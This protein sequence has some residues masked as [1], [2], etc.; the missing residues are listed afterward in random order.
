MKRSRTSADDVLPGVGVVTA[1]NVHPWMAYLPIALVALM[2]VLVTV[3]A[4]NVVSGWERQR[5]QQAFRSAAY[6]RILMVEREI[7]ESLGVVQDVGSLFD[8]SRQVG[9]R[10]FRTFV[11]PALKRYTSIAALQW[12]PRIT[13]TERVLFE[14]Q[15]RKS[16]PRFSINQASQTGELVKAG[17]RPVHFPV[18]YVQPYPFN[19]E[20]LGLDLA[21]DPEILEALQQT[22]DAGQMRATPRISLQRDGRTEYGFAARLPVYNKIDRDENEAEDDQEDTVPDTLD[23]RQQQLRGFAGGIFR[24]GDIVERALQNLS[25]SGIDMVI[26][27]IS[28]DVE[29]QYLYHHSS[30]RRSAGPGEGERQENRE[31]IQTIRVADREWEALCSVIPG[32][33]QPD[34]WSGWATLAGGLSF[35]ALLMIYLATL[36]G[37]AAKIEHLVS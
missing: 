35:T 18:L 9:R 36:L 27:D 23:L 16:F 29:R 19:R 26:H 2:G 21:S 24:I 3:Y 30:R 1:G 37:R 31:F 15:A 20:E 33:F 11:D 5:V 13:A 28:G 10:D 14:E 22:R 7:E 32:A 4:F 25:P 8:A 6:D 17:Q 34:P 12:I